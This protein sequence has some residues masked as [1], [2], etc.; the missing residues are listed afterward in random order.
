MVE[1]EPFIAA[2][3]F[4]TNGLLRV[5]RC[6]SCSSVVAICD[7]CELRWNDVAAVF[8]DPKRPSQGSFP[9]CDYCQQNTNW[10]Q[11]SIDE[12]ATEKLDGYVT[13]VSS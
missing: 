3:V 13:D 7:E 11:L 5:H 9:F 1:N 10:N 6:Q 12:L 8:K 4:C 2:C